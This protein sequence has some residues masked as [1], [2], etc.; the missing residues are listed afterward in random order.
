M[1]DGFLEVQSSGHARAIAGAFGEAAGHSRVA[2]V[3]SPLGGPAVVLAE[4]LLFAVARGPG[5][6]GEV[7]KAARAGGA[8]ANR[9]EEGAGADSVGAGYGR[10]RKLDS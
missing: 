4:R 10:E 7:P 3:V 5:E 1:S 6:R 9:A 8:A 2:R